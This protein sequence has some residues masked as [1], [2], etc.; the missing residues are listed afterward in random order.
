[1]KISLAFLC[2]TLDGFATDA[3]PNINHQ[4]ASQ[5]ILSFSTAA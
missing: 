4:T 1:M 2:T 3:A 5:P